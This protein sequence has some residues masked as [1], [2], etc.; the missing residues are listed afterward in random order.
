MSY[1]AK[2]VGGHKSKGIGILATFTPSQ[3]SNL[4]K[5]TKIEDTKR[6]Q[7]QIERNRARLKEQ[8][9]ELEK[10]NMQGRSRS[11]TNETCIHDRGRKS[12]AGKGECNRCRE[13][14]IPLDLF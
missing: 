7:D 13:D 4:H 2:L 3:L 10:R 1:A 5:E 11:S 8:E 14:A 6:R 12:G 9:R